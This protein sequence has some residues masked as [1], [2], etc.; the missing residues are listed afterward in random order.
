MERAMQNKEL[1][2]YRARLLDRWLEA[3]RAFVADCR[4]VTNPHAPLEPGGWN[5]HQIAAHVWDVDRRAYGL[6]IRRILSEDV[7][8]FENYDGDAWMS[9]TY[10]PAMPLDSML[11]DLLA[12]TEEIVPVLGALPPEAWNRLG[13]HVVQGDLTLQTWVERALA[14]VQEHLASVRA[15]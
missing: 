7:P 2:E 1:L 3:T 12:R 14:H 13:R 11:D 10:D 8:L 4:A 5:T 9:E 6:R 15:G